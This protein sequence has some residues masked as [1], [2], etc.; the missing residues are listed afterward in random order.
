[1]HER[2]EGLKTY[3]QEQGHS[4]PEVDKILEKV[5]EYDKNMATDSVFDSFEQG[6]MDLQSVIDEALGVEPQ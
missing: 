2:Y 1:M 6:V 3:L 4:D 5:A